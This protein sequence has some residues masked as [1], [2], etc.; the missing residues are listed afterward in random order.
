ME[1]LLGGRLYS[2][3]ASPNRITQ[4]W[5]YSNPQLD[6]FSAEAETSGAG[7]IRFSLVDFSGRALS[8]DGLPTQFNISDWDCGKF[9]FTQ[10]WGT[11][12]EGT[13]SLAPVPEPTTFIAG[14]LLLLP[15]GLQGIRTLR[16][17]RHAA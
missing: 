5:T 16:Y 15:F 12:I 9:S 13:I 14:A 3:G 1:L 8:G 6:S 17:R 11:V 7:W 2:G 10:P 4:I